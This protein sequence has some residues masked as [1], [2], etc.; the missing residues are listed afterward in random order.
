MKAFRSLL[1][2]FFIFL[3]CLTGVSSG[4][5]PDPRKT[6][7]NKKMP[8]FKMTPE[9][10][11]IEIEAD[12]LT[13]DK[14]EQLYQAH[15]NVEIRRGDFFLKADHARLNN[16]TNEM[17][18]WGNVVMR[19]GE[20][21]LECG[22]LE[23]NLNTRA[24]KVYDGKLFLKEQNFHIVGKEADKL[25][26]STYR[27]REGV[28]TTCDATRPPWSFSVRE[29]DVDVEGRGVAR[30]PV[31][32][33]EDI[34]IFYFPVV[35]FPVNRERQT[36]LLSPTVG[37]S[38]LYG[39][40]VKTGFYWAM[41]QEMD[42]TL[43]VDYLGKRGFKEGL[44]YRYAFPQETTGQTKFYFIDDH[45]F[46]DKRYALFSQHQQKL[47]EDFYLKWDINYVSD[48][49]Y[50]RD[51]DL[52]LPE[53]TRI[54]SR[55]LNELRS[56]LF[57]GKNWDHF[58][59]LVNGEM[60][61]NLTQINNDQT[62]QKYP[63]VSFNAYP[64]SLFKTPL[65][66]EFSFSYI[67]FWQKEGLRAHRADLSPQLSYPVRLFDV[68]K[69]TPAVSFQETAYRTYHDPTEDLKRSKSRET[70]QTGVEMSAE[71]YRVYEV[72]PTSKVSS[73]LKVAK[74][75]HTLEPSVDY[76]YS[77]RVS[78]KDLPQ[79]DS[80][81]HIPYQSQITYG[82][83]QRLLGKLGKEREDA[84][85]FEYVKLKLFQS[86][87]L[88]DP[89][90]RDYKGRGNYL[91]NIQGELWMNFNPYLSF[92]G[93]AELDPYRW[94]FNA[95]NGLAKIKDRRDD[96]LQVEYRFTQDKIQQLNFY[97]KVKTID[98]LYLYGSVRYNLL[99]K[100]RV[101]N[102]YGVLYQAQCWTLGLLVEDIN[103]SPDGTQKKELKVEAYVTLLGLGSLGHIPRVM[104]L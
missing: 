12:R 9:Q 73:L 56:V 50:P 15:G 74:W 39:P 92:R 43:Y 52:D 11:P 7:G 44:E 86:Y 33:V 37:Y 32:Y 72:D 60:F 82:F 40:K 4:K 29:L 30:G 94:N 61:N 75:M 51:F 89:Y 28:F 41:S 25:G 22:R 27:I 90:E 65:V 64:Q 36:G 13:Y 101:E 20:D 70:F 55:S 88:G 57:G 84:G 17:V 93:K 14:E 71:L 47:P 66:Y 68:L 19:E 8:E 69:V 91:S 53:K 42:S 49:F 31:F 16:A 45:V 38:N 98:P 97:T 54:D 67:N 48:R 6:L 62:V 81:D 58:S 63:Q 21:V 26:E 34:P 103:Q 95:L 18:A 80:V 46:G 5:A 99:Q 79:F 100:W 23:V 85:P 102:A 10:G 87:S 3:L 24:G 83:T 78:Q 96:A 35:P 76:S 2:A 59:L 77:P 1:I 104:S